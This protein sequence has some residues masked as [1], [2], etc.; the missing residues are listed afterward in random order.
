MLT[1][2]TPTHPTITY[3]DD[4][5]GKIFLIGRHG[6]LG[7]RVVGPLKHLG[8]GRFGSDPRLHRFNGLEHQWVDSNGDQRTG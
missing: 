1:Q 5:L 8:Q 3:Q 2:G 4:L 6:Q 7:Q